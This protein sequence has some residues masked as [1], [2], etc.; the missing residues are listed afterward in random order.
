MNPTIH[1]WTTNPQIPFGGTREDEKGSIME[2]V[3]NGMVYTTLIDETTG[4]W[5]WIPELPLA[6]GPYTVSMRVIDKAGNAN[7][8]I[9]V[10]LH[11]D[12]TAPDKPDIL[13]VVDDEGLQQ[14]WLTPGA[15]TDDKTPTLSGS[16]EAGSIVRLYDGSNEIGSA[17]ADQ[18]GR[19]EITPTAELSDGTHRF[20]VTSTDPMGHT[21]A[22]SDAFSLTIEKD[23]LPPIGDGATITHASDNVGS[24]TGTLL[25]GTITDDTTPTLNGTAK[26]GSTVR[27]QYRAENGS[28]IAGGNAVLNGTDW[29]WTPNPALA[30]GK[31]EFRANDGSGWTDEFRLD[32]DLTPGDRCEITHAYDDFGTYTG[33]L[34]SGAITDDRTPTLHGR[35]EANSV[36]YIHY[37]N[38]LGAWELLASVIVG[39]DGQWKYD[40][41]RLAPG[42]YEFSAEKSAVHDAD[43]KSFGLKIVLEGS[44]VPTI[45]GAFDDAGTITGIVKHNGITDDTTP[46]LTGTAEANSLVVI[47]YKSDTSSDNAVFTVRADSRGVWTFTPDELTIGIWEFSVKRPEGEFLSDPYNL[48]IVPDDTKAYSYGFENKTSSYLYQNH[49]YSLTQDISVKLNWGTATFYNYEP[50]VYYPDKYGSTGLWAQDNSQVEFTLSGVRDFSFDIAGGTNGT[51]TISVYDTSNNLISSKEYTLKNSGYA[52]YDNPDHLSFN[53][54]NQLLGKIVISAS[55]AYGFIIDNLTWLPALHPSQI[56]DE[57]NNDSTLLVVDDSQHLSLSIADVLASGQQDLY[58]DDG[59]THLMVNGKA[60]DILQLEDILPEGSETSGWTALAGTVTIAGCEYQVY[61]NGD[62]EL[63][64]QDGVKTELV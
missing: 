34:S 62:A 1:K 40:S 36:V 8:P 47:S 18:N 54:D 26:A 33:E 30:E 58:I 50:S 6:D 44:F 42:N 61:S 38:V 45:D 51:A 10:I 39:A 2:I 7:T 63:L 49:L 56:F 43:A 13:R 25:D 57:N 24:A 4:K 60:G 12:T 53:F 23:S 48:S 41:D 17:L 31:Y 20:T 9:Q 35:G 14:G 52:G 16:A 37:H 5:S 59:K 15:K 32:I 29:T 11:V 3:L 27:I 64:V 28:W 19:W 46:T 21:S 55:D 22:A